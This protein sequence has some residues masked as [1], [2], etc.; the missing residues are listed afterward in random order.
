[1]KTILSKINKVGLFAFASGLMLI[2]AMSAFKSANLTPPADG[3]YNVT[4]INPALSHSDPTNQAIGSSTL[5]PDEVNESGCA[6]TINTGDLC[7]VYLDFTANATAVPA[8]VSDV[9]AFYE[10]ITDDAQLPE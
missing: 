1:M 2:G 5:P 3:W 6:R 7:S 8:K 4:I 9:N 10:S